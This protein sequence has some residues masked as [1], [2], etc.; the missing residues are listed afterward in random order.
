DKPSGENAHAWQI[1]FTKDLAAATWVG[2]KNQKQVPIYGYDGGVYTKLWGFNSA[3]R[4]NAAFMRLAAQKMKDYAQPFDRWAHVGDP[5]AGNTPSPK[6]RDDGGRGGAACRLFNIGCPQTDPAQ[7]GGG[8][9]GGGG[10]NP[11]PTGGGGGGGGGTPNTTG[12]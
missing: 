3:G 4:I 9:G 12:A 8:G 10:G 5:N 7:P 2:N 1:N 6:K 11:P